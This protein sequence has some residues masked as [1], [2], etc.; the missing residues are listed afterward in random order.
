MASIAKPAEILLNQ[1]EQIVEAQ[2]VAKGG[3][4]ANS[5]TAGVVDQFTVSGQ[6]AAQAA[7][8][9]TPAN[10][11]T[12]TIASPTTVIDSN[13]ALQNLNNTLASIGLNATNI[14]KIDGIASLINNFDPAAFAILAYQLKAQEI[15]PPATFTTNPS[16]ATSLSNSA[17]AAASLGT[18]VAATTLNA[19]NRD[20]AIQK[21]NTALG[22]VG[23]NSAD[24]SKIDGIASLI[25]NFDPAAFA[26]LAHQLKAQEIAPHSS[27][28]TT[29]PAQFG[30]PT[31]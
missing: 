9:Y 12:Q 11:I 10:L 5:T 18:E 27:A 26:V 17:A 21:L 23:L 8:L 30:S 2:A 19:A 13:A 29:V 31:A 24:I 7:G 25:N 15:T 4:A 6:N 3:V 16:G 20:E 22:A 14:N 28:P 1:V